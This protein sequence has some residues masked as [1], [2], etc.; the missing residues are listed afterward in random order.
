MYFCCNPYL[1]QVKGERSVVVA[2]DKSYLKAKQVKLF[3]QY[4]SDIPRMSTA[5]LN[6]CT[7]VNLQGH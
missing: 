4:D 2:S 6:L 1:H 5:L 3:F 7:N